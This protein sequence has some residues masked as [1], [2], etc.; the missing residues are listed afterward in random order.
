MFKELINEIKGNHDIKDKKIAMLKAKAKS[1]VHCAGNT[2]PHLVSAN[3]TT[4]RY[5]CKPKDKEKSLKMKRVLKKI[6][7]TTKGKMARQKA[8][9]TKKF[10]YN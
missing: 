1:K 3:G 6:S 5:V 10:R 2:T 8:Q 9:D 4:F 7:H